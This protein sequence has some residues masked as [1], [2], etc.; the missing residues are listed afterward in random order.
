MSD[1][2]LRPPPFLKVS[3]ISRSTGACAVEAA[4]HRHA[5][6]MQLPG[7][8]AS[9]CRKAHSGDVKH[10]E[11]L[12]ARNTPAWASGA[13]GDQAFRAALREIPAEP[14]RDRH[15]TERTAWA[16]LAE[17]LWT[18]IDNVET[19]WN[20]QWRR[21]EL[22]RLVTVA[23]PRALSSDRRIRLVRDFAKEAF[24]SHRTAIDLV[25]RDR[26]DGN[27]HAFLALPT[28]P[29]DAESWGDKD[30]EQW[31]RRRIFALRQAWQRHVNLAMERE[32]LRGRIDMRSRKDQGRMLE[33]ESYDRRIAAR[34]EKAGGT[35]REECRA[36]AARHRNQALL[37]ERPE[38]IIAE[39]QAELAAFTLAE[40]LADLAWRLDTTLLALPASM[41]AR[42]AGSS[43]LV[44]TGE[45]TTDGLNLYVFRETGGAA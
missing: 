19:C 29:L 32:G 30:R 8:R 18:D 3:S 6:K 7:G 26:S 33:S 45:R 44:P 23:L 34:V 5:M 15:S 16:R 37:R 2:S 17:R 4:A 43:G 14:G 9:K 22:A 39:A 28:R 11:I 25:V 31:S 13:Y 12:M 10:S 36:E 21:A 24:G 35:A 42:V 27:P 20:R 41:V 40:L 38:I 1:I